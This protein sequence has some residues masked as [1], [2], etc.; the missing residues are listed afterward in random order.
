MQQKIIYAKMRFD[1]ITTITNVPFFAE[2]DY[3]SNIEYQ[4]M[5]ALGNYYE[6]T[7]EEYVMCFTKTMCVKDGVLQEYIVPDS[8]LLANAKQRKLAKVDELKKRTLYA[9]LKY[10]NFI[11]IATEKAQNNIIGAMISNFT[12]KQ[13]LDIYGNGIELS[14]TEFAEI[15]DMLENRNF[16]CY[17]TEAMLI[18]VI[19]T[20]HN[21]TTLDDIDVEAEFQKI[22]NIINNV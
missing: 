10:K 3:S 1:I 21:M 7:Y 12:T 8:V 14:R 18:K 13:W 17:K 4:E 11:L 6:A 19:S 16:L 2:K 15:R 22:N 9:T 20:A 5:I